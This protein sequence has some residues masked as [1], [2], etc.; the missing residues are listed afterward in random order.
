MRALF[1]FAQG[2]RHLASNEFA[3]VGA[4]FASGAALNPVGARPERIAL[5][6]LA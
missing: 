4:H 6:R 1:S 2:S 3:V 5:T